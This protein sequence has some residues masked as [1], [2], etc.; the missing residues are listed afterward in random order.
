MTLRDKMCGVSL[1]MAVTLLFAI[2]AEAA[3]P[4]QKTQAPG[5]YR[6]MLGDFEVTTLS[7]G[8]F[9]MEVGKMLT[10]ITPQ[11][12]NAALAHSFL[13]EPVDTSVNGYLINTGSKLIL[14]DT[15]S[16]SVFGPSVGKLIS[17]IKASGYQPEQVDEIYITHMHG[18]HVG[19]LLADGKR[20][21]PNAVVRASKAE[22][23][24]WLSKANM[25]AAPADRKDEFKTA[26]TALNPYIAA[27]KFKQI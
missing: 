2:S 9:P 8:I 6:M 20:A 22:A 13:K 19:G 27:G 1:A 12:L 25:D 7:D 5:Y 21:Y 24:Y 16:G 26:M 17:N 4:Q 14:I 18:Y 10:N 3:A 23:D 11:Q 15:G